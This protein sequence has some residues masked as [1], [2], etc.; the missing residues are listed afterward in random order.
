MFSRKAIF[1]SEIEQHGDA[2]LPGKR[3]SV[4]APRQ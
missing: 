1:G 4:E 2:D 3:E